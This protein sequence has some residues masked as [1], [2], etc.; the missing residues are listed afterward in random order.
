MRAES[1]LCP[2]WAGVANCVRCPCPGVESPLSWA[3][4]ASIR[5]VRLGADMFK[6][7]L[8]TVFLL[9]VCSAIAC[10]QAAVEYGAA[11][12]T[13]A[14][15]TSGAASGMNRLNQRLTGVLQQKTSSEAVVSPRNPASTRKSAA[16]ATSKPVGSRSTE[17]S[18]IRAG[19]AVANPKQPTQSP[20]KYPNTITLSIDK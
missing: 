13:S 5:P 4:L 16:R 20:S 17:P 10:S 7:A 11:A 1:V 14:T 2:K 9:T 6:Q 12:G 18:P 3:T 8:Q 19:A 15:T